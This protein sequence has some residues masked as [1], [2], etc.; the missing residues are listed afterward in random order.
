MIVILKYF[1]LY[2][3]ICIIIDHKQ[4]IQIANGAI[5]SSGLPDISLVKYL[6]LIF[7]LMHCVISPYYWIK[8]LRTKIYYWIK[9]RIV[10]YK[11]RKLVKKYKLKT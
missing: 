3:V 2:W 7:T 11:L 5:K 6:A 4:I 10:N 1:I 9:N 8:I